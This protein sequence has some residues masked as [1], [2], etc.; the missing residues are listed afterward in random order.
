MAK[1]NL[2]IT[3]QNT[4]N[5]IV[6]HSEEFNCNPT[7]FCPDGYH[8]VLSKVITIVPGV[9]WTPDDG[10]DHPGTT[11][12]QYVSYPMPAN[13]ECYFLASWNE[14]DEATGCVKI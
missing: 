12:C 11:Y 10:E 5:D 14:I 1:F 3:F 13:K 9:H 4:E 7:E 2:L 8:P 6:L